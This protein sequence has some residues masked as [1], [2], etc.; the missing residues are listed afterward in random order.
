MARPLRVNIEDGWYHAYARGLN[1]M[2]IYGDDRDRG[3]FLELLEAIPNT[4]VKLLSGDGTLVFPGESS[5]LP[6]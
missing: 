3:H 5:T 4:D 6:G 1:R 2:G